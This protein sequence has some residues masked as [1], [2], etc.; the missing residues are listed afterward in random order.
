MSEPEQHFQ[1][2]LPIL[3]QGAAK[4]GVDL[5]ALET[6][7]LLQFLSLLNKWN[8]TFNLSAVREPKEML[9][10]HLLDSL[11]LLSLVREQRS[12]SP[13]KPF[14]VLDVGT[15]PG[16]PGIPLAICMP[17]TEFVLLDS[18]GKK[19]RFVFQ[20]CL[21]LG[22]KNVEVENTRIETYQS[23][24]QIDIVVSRAFASL[25]DFARGCEPVAGF[26]TKLIAMK[27][28]YPTEE[29]TALPVHW[30]I[31]RTHELKIPG[32]DGDRHFIEL[33]KKH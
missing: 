24:R 27:G 14:T 23:A 12:V 16:L 25:S 9:S 6:T 32:S 29:I 4:L 5:S 3:K 18:N 30:Q 21:E 28:Q 1:Q 26:N 19:T 11:S 2:F 20:A 15:G 7:R 31:I 13:T 33:A 17:D 10:R 22:I 8:K